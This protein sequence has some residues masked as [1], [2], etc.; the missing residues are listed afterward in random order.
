MCLCHFY[1]ESCYSSLR[2]LQQIGPSNISVTQVSEIETHCQHC[3]VSMIVCASFFP[4]VEFPGGGSASLW[5]LVFSGHPDVSH[6]IAAGKVRISQPSGFLCRSG[7]F[8]KCSVTNLLYGLTDLQKMCLM[9]SGI[10][11]NSLDTDVQTFY[12]SVGQCLYWGLMSCLFFD[13]HVLCQI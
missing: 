1:F 3:F 5:R 8:W 6:H 2:G 13:V 12:K 9:L 7:R 4:S 11:F 10:S